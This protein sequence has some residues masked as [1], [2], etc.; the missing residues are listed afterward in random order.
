MGRR[1][2][3]DRDVLEESYREATETAAAMERSGNYA[4]ASELWGEAAKQAVTLT[5]REWCN[6]RKTYCKAWQG[7]REKRQ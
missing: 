5:Q 3:I 4:R 2:K 1:P 6:T 7:K